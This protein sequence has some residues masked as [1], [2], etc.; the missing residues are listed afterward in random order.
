VEAF[1][2]ASLVTGCLSVFFSCVIGPA[3][4]GL[5]SAADIKDFLSKPVPAA[6]VKVLYKK[7]SDAERVRALRRVADDDQIAQLKYMMNMGKWKVASAYSAILL[8]LPRTL[9][10]TA[11]NAFLIGLGIYMG[12]LCTARLVVEYGSGSIGIFVFYLVSAVVGIGVYIAAD[13]L[14]YLENT[15]ILRFRKI[16]DVRRVHQSSKLGME[17]DTSGGNWSARR[18]AGFQQSRHVRQGSR[19]QYTD[20]A[21]SVNM[22]TPVGQDER[23]VEEMHTLAE[24]SI[25]GES[26]SKEKDSQLPSTMSDST[27]PYHT[28]PTN[29]QTTQ[30]PSE[31]SLPA[32]HSHAAS[33]A[34]GPES[35]QDILQDLLRVHEESLRINQRLLEAL[36]LT[37]TR[38]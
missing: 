11:L 14:K 20:G 12:K 28:S 33:H 1:F 29:E 26:T 10:S 24:D 25:S 35:M 27:D 9:L 32:V 31:P 17:G 37:H 13:T 30:D 19:I 18:T 36:K 6:D 15:P 2:V 8:V 3:F 4:H 38:S 21:A 22:D 5:H 23:C 34:H 16:T 7:L